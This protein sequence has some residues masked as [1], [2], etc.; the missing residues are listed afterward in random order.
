MRGDWFWIQGSSDYCGQVAFESPAS[1][2]LHSGWH[3]V[4]LGRRSPSTSSSL[5]TGPRFCGRNLQTKRRTR[6]TYA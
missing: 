1:A 4:N 5:R 2:D 3:Q 6:R